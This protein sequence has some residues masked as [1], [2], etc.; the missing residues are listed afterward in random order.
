MDLQRLEQQRQAL[1]QSLRQLRTSLRLW[2]TWEAEYEGLKE[3]I[4]SVTGDLNASTL[5]HISQT[6]NGELVNGREIRDIVG[7]DKDSPRNATEI[8]GM[9]SRRQEYVQKNIETIQRQFWDAEAKLEELDFVAT[10]RGPNAN[11]RITE[12][13]EELDDDGNVIS[14]N[15]SQP[16]VSTTKI[17]ETL[18]KAGLSETDIPAQ[19][20]DKVHTA[21]DD[22]P[23][24]T[25]LVATFPPPGIATADDDSAQEDS[26]LERPP[27]RK[28]SV[29]FTADTKAA[30][31]PV[32]LDS[33]DGRKS[34]SFAE[35]VAVAPAASTTETRSVSFSPMIEEIP[36]P[37]LG[38]ASPDFTG[39]LDVKN[40]AR[41]YFQP[42][43]K[44]I[45]LG[46]DDHSDH[47]DEVIASQI[48]LP[49]DESPEDA[50]IRREMLDYHLNEVGH[51]V[52]QI[53]LDEAETDGD[54]TA[55]ASDFAS[56]EHPEEDTPYTSGP[57]DSEN[58]DE[59][60]YGRS[61]NRVVSDEYRKEMQELE[62]RLIGNLGPNPTDQDVKVLDPELDTQNIRTLAIRSKA[63][64]MSSGSSDADKPSNGK[65]RVSFA[66]ALDVAE[67]P[68]IKAAKTQEDE[69]TSPR[70]ASSVG[71]DDASIGDE[72][73]SGPPGKI[74]A[75]KLLERPTSTTGAAPP[76]VDQPDA[77]MQ[78]RE[79]ATEY[80]RHRNEFIRQQGGFSADK[81]QDEEEGEMM[82]EKDGKL[83]KMSRFKAARIK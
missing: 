47:N 18:R 50:K 37:P 49:E 32:R 15:L 76:S 14:S 30:P 80:Y 56:S 78:R 13:H 70:L 61:K 35:K 65:K 4:Q 43:D 41:G 22:N 82:E 48:I 71:K 64:S 36:P 9:I 5:I 6:Y 7:L 27:I 67:P 12:I 45:E 29:S 69:N 42:I 33:E 57:S 2:Q 75:D 28:K 63:D 23:A 55:S 34:V 73:S 59:D 39:E 66:E 31:E 68:P 58:D 83:K 60:E 26:G 79:L 11:L 53:D 72:T 54:D 51:V 52:A 74:I 40:N 46:H 20:S 1:E 16:E 19:P 81:D 38:P 24:A 8:L 17:V 25:G 62:R 10:N 3:E 21:P 77:L 44:T